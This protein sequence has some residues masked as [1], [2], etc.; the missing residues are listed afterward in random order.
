SCAA[1]RAVLVLFPVF[2]L[3]PAQCAWIDGAMRNVELLREVELSGSGAAR[4]L[5]L[6]HA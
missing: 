4:R 2:L 6:R 3:V 5:V 1:Q